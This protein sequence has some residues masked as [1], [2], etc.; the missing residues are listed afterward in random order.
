MEHF[1]FPLGAW[2]IGILL[3]VLCLIV[4][5]IFHCLRRSKTDVPLEEPGVAQSTPESEDRHN[6]DFEDN[7]DTKLHTNLVKINE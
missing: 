4:E 6:R 3:S 7:E 5:I 2:L 1:I